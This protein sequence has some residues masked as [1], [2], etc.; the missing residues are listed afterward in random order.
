MDSAQIGL[1]GILIIGGMSILGALVFSYHAMKASSKAYGVLVRQIV[2]G[3]LLLRLLTI[4]AIIFI[5]A[6]LELARELSDSTS[7][8]LSG[9]AGYV[10]GGASKRESGE[11]LDPAPIEVARDAGPRIP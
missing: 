1:I 4:F 3:G 11:G 2:R 10:L 6:V 5:A 9:I 8:I 7:T